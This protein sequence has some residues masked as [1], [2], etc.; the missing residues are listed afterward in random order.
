MERV[1]QGRV[2]NTGIYCDMK[3][4]KKPQKRWR[5]TEPGN[6]CDLAMLSLEEFKLPVIVDPDSEWILVRESKSI[7]RN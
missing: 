5:I 7:V 3:R 6:S 4:E 1:V 2:K